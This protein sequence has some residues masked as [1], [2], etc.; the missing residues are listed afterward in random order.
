MSAAAV[1]KNILLLIDRV[2]EEDVGTG[3]DVTTE[4]I[5]PDDAVG[6]A[7]FVAR[8]EGVI[9]GLEVARLVFERI[10][11]EIR[12]SSIIQDGGFVRAGQVFAEA[13]GPSGGILTGE[14]VALNFLRHLSG[15]ATLTSRYVRAVEGTGARII[16]TRKTTPG[17]RYLEKEAV[18]VGG[19]ANHRMG[20]YDMVLIKDNHIAAAGGITAAVKRC[21]ERMIGQGAYLKIEV[22]TETQSQVRE[23]AELLV[24]RIMLDNMS[25]AEMQ[26]AVGLVRRMTTG[27]SHIELEA[28]GA[29]TL[30]EVRDVAE[31]GVDL[32][33][34]GAL[35]HSAP[36][37]D[38]SLDMD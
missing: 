7:R 9:S 34:V 18:R 23:A 5:I 11:P 32:I 35:T 19:G 16:D 12:V 13:Q 37:L 28:S 3:G 17:L 29:V 25:I 14:R 30:A 38:I 31:T 20:L 26:A 8:E 10:N 4:W 15:V 21:R 2:I 36:A 6:V 27:R 33:S 1:H 22:E 24:D